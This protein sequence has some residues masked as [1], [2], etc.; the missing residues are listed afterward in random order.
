MQMYGLHFYS[1]A[2]R[3]DIDKHRMLKKHSDLCDMNDFMH[4]K[5]PY[6]ANY[7]RPLFMGTPEV[8]SEL[9]PSKEA[10]AEHTTEHM[11]TAGK[12]CGSVVGFDEFGLNKTLISGVG[13][14]LT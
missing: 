8:T 1:I 6:L 9:S 12:Q 4:D 11:E 13:L 10:A 3:H 7:V 14:H 5:S 2:E